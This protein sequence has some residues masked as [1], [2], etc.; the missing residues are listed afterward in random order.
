MKKIV[1]LTSIII[2]ATVFSCTRVNMKSEQ[3]TATS[4]EILPAFQQ[5]LDSANVSGSI[6]IFDPAKSIYYSND[7]ERCEMGHLPA[8]TFKIPNSIIALETGVIEDDSTLIG[9][10]GEKR[11]MRAWEKDLYFRDA[12]HVSCVP[13]YQEIA[14]K[15]GVERMTEYLAKLDYGNMIVDSATIATF[16]LE[17]ESKIS[18]FEQIGFLYRFFDSKLLISARTETL[19]KQLM[20]IEENDTFRLSG[21]TGWSVRN[22]NNNGWFVGYLEQGGEVYFIATNIYPKVEF[23]MDLFPVIRREISMEAFKVVR[24]SGGQG[25]RGSGGQVIRG[26]GDQVVR[27]N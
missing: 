18:Q 20:V 13:C 4:K 25:V 10:D 24:G 15:I 11:R 2:L 17:G 8:S 6:L 23:N 1:F 22:G 5:I 27:G 3:K 21:K 19:M 12:F 7:F 16:W 14:C 9:W 26:S